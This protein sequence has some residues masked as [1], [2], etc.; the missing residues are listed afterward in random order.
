MLSAWTGSSL[1]EVCKS[2]IRS[3]G[4]QTKTALEDKHDSE[5]VEGSH[6]LADA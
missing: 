6:G 2:G 5:L 1:A 4:A 3:L